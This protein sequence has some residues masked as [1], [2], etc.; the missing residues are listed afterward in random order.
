MKIKKKYIILIIIA[1]AAISAAVWAWFTSPKGNAIADADQSEIDF[2][3]DPETIETDESVTDSSFITDAT[4]ASVTDQ[5]DSDTDINEVHTSS[6]ADESKDREGILE[7][8]GNLVIIV[9]D[10]EDTFGE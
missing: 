2:S 10:G 5:S 9:P 6:S 8:D 1:L 7:E 3:S 4:S